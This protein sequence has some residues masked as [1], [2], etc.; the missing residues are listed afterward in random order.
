MYA[1]R[2]EIVVNYS[3]CMTFLCQTPLLTTLILCC[4]NLDGFARKCGKIK[5]T[6]CLSSNDFHF[7]FRRHKNK[8]Y[9]YTELSD[10]IGLVIICQR[11]HV[12][13]S[14]FR[15]WQPFQVGVVCLVLSVPG[16]LLG[17]GPMPS[18][19]AVRSLREQHSLTP[20]GEGA[21]L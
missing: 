1:K 9:L 19:C 21:A 20:S 4:T 10:C 8:L 7:H 11:G 14:S 15:L 12:D 2:I 3:F 16:A 6:M 17:R 18:P 13:A 5:G